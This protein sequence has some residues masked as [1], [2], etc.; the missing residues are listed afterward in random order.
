M[1][2][3]RVRTI[4]ILEGMVLLNDVGNIVY[5]K[6]ELYNNITLQTQPPVFKKNCFPPQQMITPYCETLFPMEWLSVL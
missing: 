3:G 6:G 4:V 5:G 2:S 1:H